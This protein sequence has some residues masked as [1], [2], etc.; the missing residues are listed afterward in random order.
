MKLGKRGEAWKEGCCLERG[1][2]LGKRDSINVLYPLHVHSSKSL[3]RT[4]NSFHVKA[5]LPRKMK[6]KI[7]SL[8]KCYSMW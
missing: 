6:L 3:V 8:I 1:L 2:M 7:A 5:S 4:E